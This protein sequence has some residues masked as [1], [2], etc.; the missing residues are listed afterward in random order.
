[1]PCNNKG[2]TCK[3]PVITRGILLNV[4]HLGVRTRLKVLA[5]KIVGIQNELLNLEQD[6]QTSGRS[7]A[8]GGARVGGDIAQRKWRLTTLL[9]L[10]HPHAHSHSHTCMQA[11]THTHIH[12][13]IQAHA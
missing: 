3:C 1:M 13:Y 9:S 2:Y 10:A 5:I 12:T 11:Y 4:H 7:W 6:Q 8:V